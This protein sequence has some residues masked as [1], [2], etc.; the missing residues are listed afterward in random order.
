MEFVLLLFILLLTNIFIDSSNA[1]VI[2]SKTN[3]VVNHKNIIIAKSTSKSSTIRTTD[4]KNDDLLSL[5]KQSTK[6]EENTLNINS[7]K[8][9]AVAFIV[10]ALSLTSFNV[11]T[12]GIVNGAVSS[13]YTGDIDKLLIFDLRF[14]YKPEDVITTLKDWGSQGRIK[15]LI[16]E[17]IDCVF[18]HAGYRALF[19]VIINNLLKA[20][21]NTFPNFIKLKVLGLI[22]VGLA[23]LDFTEDFFQVLFTGSYELFSKSIETSPYFPV[24]INLGSFVNQ[25]KWLTVRGASISILLIGMVTLFGYLKNSFSRKEKF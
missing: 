22:P 23:I 19:V 21:T 17:F 3:D 8:L 15:Y 18:Y 6:L 9:A 11:L 20:F 10:T 2:S 1:L 5:F 4:D 14:G 16:I 13:G 24:L 25:V 12:S 7:W